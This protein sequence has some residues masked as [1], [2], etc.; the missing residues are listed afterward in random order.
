MTAVVCL[1]IKVGGL[2][3]QNPL[4]HPPETSALL[5]PARY[6]AA[7]RNA[8]VDTLFSV[9]FPNFL[10]SF[11]GRYFDQELPWVSQGH[12]RA[13][14]GEDQGAEGVKEKGNDSQ[15]CALRAM[16]CLEGW[17]ADFTHQLILGRKPLFLAQ[18]VTAEPRI[19]SGRSRGSILSLFPHTLRTH[20]R[21]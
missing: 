17:R 14:E 18:Q 1:T 15:A 6:P 10:L 11:L 19:G 4:L 20:A 9:T 3:T 12:R 8:H 2:A 7:L 5:R 13:E 16:A 21:L